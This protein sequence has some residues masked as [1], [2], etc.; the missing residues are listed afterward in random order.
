MD[1]PVFSARSMTEILDLSATPEVAGALQSAVTRG[2]MTTDTDF[3][4][5]ASWWRNEEGFLF[6]TDATAV[7]PGFRRVELQW[8]SDDGYRASA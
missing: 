7:V 5:A 4:T 8:E 3:T 1:K 6:A 2:I